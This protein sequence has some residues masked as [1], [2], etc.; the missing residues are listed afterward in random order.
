MH[1][2]ALPGLLLIVLA[3][4]GTSAVAQERRY[5]VEIVIF[6]NIDT[7]AGELERWRS[8]VHV[9]EF[10]EVILFEDGT[11]NAV[12]IT[13]EDRVENEETEDRDPG[14]YRPLPAERLQLGGMVEKL[15]GSGRYRVLRHLAWRQPADG[16][17]QAVPIR[18]RAGEPITVQ[19]PIRDFEELYRL[20]EETEGTGS[21]AGIG[22]ETDDTRTGSDD[23]N[24]VAPVTEA[25]TEG[26]RTF[27]TGPMFRTRFRPLTRPAAVHPLD[28]TVRVAVSRYLHVTTDLH[29]TTPVEWTAF[30][31]QSSQTGEVAGTDDEEAIL[32]PAPTGEIARQQHAI[33]PD[34]RT[35]LSYP[36]RQSR[37]M[38]SGE[39]HYLDHPV[40]G[41]LIRV[42]RAPEEEDADSDATE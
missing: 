19:I 34:G 21:G 20:E 6:E 17:E 13:D 32:D 18:V 16:R 11:G 5:D 23:D 25:A 8:R 31:G 38:R 7:S 41:L 29:L 37:R 39:L 36:F 26:A 12:F 35:M 14:G 10:H 4:A 15:E 1:H 22:L 2:R 9:P 27:A 28:G 24:D 42:D 40:L 3:A 33:G 30:P